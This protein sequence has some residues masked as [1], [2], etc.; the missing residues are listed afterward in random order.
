MNGKQSSQQDAGL[1]NNIQQLTNTHGPGPMDG[2]L[3]H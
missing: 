1:I 3:W 2:Q